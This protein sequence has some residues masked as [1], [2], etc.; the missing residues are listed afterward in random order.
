MDIPC[1]LPAWAIAL[2][3]VVGIGIN[4]VVAVVFYQ[5]GKQRAGR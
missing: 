3:I 5:V 1:N 4:L 2:Q